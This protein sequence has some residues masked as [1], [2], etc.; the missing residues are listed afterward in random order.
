[1]ILKLSPNSLL[2]LPNKDNKFFVSIDFFEFCLYHFFGCF[3]NLLKL[4]LKRSK[5]DYQN[6]KDYIVVSEEL[7]EFYEDFIIPVFSLYCFFMGIDFKHEAHDVF[8]RNLR[9]RNYVN[10]S[11]W[12]IK[13]PY[14]VFAVTISNFL[15]KF[16]YA[17]NL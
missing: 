17:K 11:I 5:L 7:R 2:R 13:N 9:K 3:F 10:P 1:M 14:R 4:K 12:F 6:M 8:F 15:Q 16:Y